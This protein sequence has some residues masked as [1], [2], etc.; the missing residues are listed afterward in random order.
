MLIQ[1]NKKHL[2]LKF[3]KKTSKSSTQ[4]NQLIR[5]IRKIKKSTKVES[6]SQLIK[7]ICE[8]LLDILVKALVL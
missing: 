2:I 7:L 4:N 6:P 5:F 1:Y 3:T 8:G